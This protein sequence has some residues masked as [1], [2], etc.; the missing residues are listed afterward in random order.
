MEVMVKPD[1]IVALNMIVVLLP[2][3]SVKPVPVP[4][5]VMVPPDIALESNAVGTTRY[6]PLRL[7]SSVRGGVVAG[8]T[9]A[10]VVGGGVTAVA[11]SNALCSAA[12]T[13]GVIQLAM[14]LTSK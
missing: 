13:V 8:I 6:S 2:A 11:V 3:G 4:L 10:L 5:M 7:T 14:R 1:A 9:S 12:V